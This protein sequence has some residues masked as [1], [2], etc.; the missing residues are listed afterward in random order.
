[1]TN[2]MNADNLFAVFTPFIKYP[3]LLVHTCTLCFM[4]KG[5]STTLTTINQTAPKITQSMWQL[6]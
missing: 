4:K 5:T 2:H 1:M 3:G 6:L